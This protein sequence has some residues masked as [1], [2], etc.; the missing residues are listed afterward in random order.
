MQGALLTVTQVNEYL[1]MMLD[2]DPRLGDL[3]VRGE[4]SNFTNHYKTG[5]FYFSL[6][7]VLYLVKGMLCIISK[8]TLRFAA[9]YTSPKYAAI[10]KAVFYFY[11]IF[12]YA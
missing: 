8:K 10:E 12:V 6:K 9:Y 4:I 11:V 3:L 1:R 2:S 7:C 5:H